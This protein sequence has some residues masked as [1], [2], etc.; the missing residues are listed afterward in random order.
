MKKR[1]FT[2]LV[3]GAMMM[4]ALTGCGEAKDVEQTEKKSVNTEVVETMDVE[5]EDTEEVS[6]EVTTEASVNVQAPEGGDTQAVD[7]TAEVADD[8]ATDEGIYDLEDGIVYSI[9]QS[10]VFTQDQM[11]YGAEY[12]IAAFG[13]HFPECELLSVTYD[14]RFSSSQDEINKQQYGDADYVVFTTD[15]TV[16]AD[17]VDGPLNAGETYEEYQWILTMNDAGQWELVSSGWQ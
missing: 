17:Y 3:L 4:G 10:P 5:V 9:C 8:T 11:M 12:V 1:I 6:V 14:D 15:F 2:G 7:Q 16:P 13:T